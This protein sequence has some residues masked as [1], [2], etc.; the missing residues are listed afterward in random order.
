MLIPSKTLWECVW[1]LVGI[2]RCWN[3]LHCVLHYYPFVF[4]ISSNVLQLSFSFPHSCCSESSPTTEALHWGF[5]STQGHLWKVFLLAFD[6]VGEHSL[7]ILPNII[8]KNVTSCVQF[9]CLWRTICI[10]GD[11]LPESCSALPPN[12]VALLAISW[13]AIAFSVTSCTG[14]PSSRIC[15]QGFCSSPDWYSIWWNSALQFDRH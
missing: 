8:I 1:D 14:C 6:L 11:S 9:F 12:M 13:S 7:E 5:S 10:N 15:L 2:P 3:P 4:S